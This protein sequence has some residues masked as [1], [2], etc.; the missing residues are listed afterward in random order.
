MIRWTCTRSIRERMGKIMNTN[1]K[2]EFVQVPNTFV[3]TDL[4]DMPDDAMFSMADDV[5]ARLAVEFIER[6]PDDLLKV[7][8]AVAALEAAPNDKDCYTALFRL[9]HDLKGMAGTFDYMLITVIGNDLCR[10]IERPVPITPRRLKVVRF[11]LEAMKL[12]EQKRMTGA[13][14]P[15]GMRIVD[16]LHS[17]AQKVLLEE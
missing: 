12:V 13:D 14:N 6:L 9:V 8:E 1:Q 11:H 15:Q 16:T 3:N 17:M 10:F 2:V 7:E 4:E 5:I